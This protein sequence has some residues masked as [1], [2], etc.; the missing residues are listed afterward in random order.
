[1]NQEEILYSHLDLLRSDLKINDIKNVAI[2][3]YSLQFLRS[4]ERIPKEA[5]ISEVLKHEDDLLEYL[6]NAF[7]LVEEKLPELKGIY[8]IFPTQGISQKTLFT[9]LLQANNLELS[10]EEWAELIDRLF[11]QL[12]EN[13]GRKSGEHYSPESVNR[14]GIQLLKPRFGTFYDGSPGVG[15]TLIQ[16]HKFAKSLQG[17]IRLCGQELNYNNWALAKF[18]LL[19]HGVDGAKLE[20]GDTLLTPSHIEGENIMKFDHVMMDFPFS[21]AIDEYEKLIQD[22]YNRFIY[23]KPPRRSADMAF[24]MHALSSLKQTGK[25]VLIVT[26]GT[27]F[28]GA[29]EQAIRENM[30]AADVIEAVIALPE[31]IYAETG[32]Q[33]NL[34][35]LNKNKPNERKG[36]ILFINAEDEFKAFNRRRNHLDTENIKKVVKA[37]E[38]GFEIEKFSTLIPTSKIDDAD[39][40]CR[41]YLEDGEIEVESF[42]TVKVIKESLTKNGTNNLPISNLSET[43]YRGMNISAK[44]VDEGQGEYKII[45]LSDVKNGEFALDQLTKVTLKRKSK[46]EMYLVQKGD[47]IVSNRGTSIKIAVVPENEGNIILSHNFLGIRCNSQLDPYFLKAYLES[48]IGQYLLTSKQIGTNILTINPKDLKDIHVPVVDINE[49]MGIAKGFRDVEYS[50]Q[51]RLRQIEDEKKQQMLKLYEQMGIRNSFEITS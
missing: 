33:T 26:N 45:K 29:S 3:I 14:L 17:D 23:G 2:P 38:E 21:V 28:R 12:Y 51:E 9:F 31:N 46:V 5:M 20:Q 16:A 50:Y 25:A 47:V 4:N 40:L 11:N 35:V 22:P 19:F 18:N 27:L 39:L 49:Q 10:N 36:K 48:P 34:L 42:G 8:K 37:Y 13:E 44:S 32:I 43:I 41:R 7:N 1:L 15:G 24:I 6:I 30:I